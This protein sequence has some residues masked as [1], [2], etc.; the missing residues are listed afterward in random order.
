MDLGLGIGLIIVAFLIGIG[1]AALFIYLFLKR[2][3]NTIIKK[4]DDA[5]IEAQKIVKKAELDALD[6]VAKM[7]KRI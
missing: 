1:A 4:V 6:V 5:K 3:H 2:K 7:K